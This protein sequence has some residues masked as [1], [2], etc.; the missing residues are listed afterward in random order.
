[1]PFKHKQYNSITIS[2]TYYDSDALQ[3]L[4]KEKLNNN[5]VAEWEIAFYSF[6]EEWLNESPE[7]EVKTS[8]STGIPKKIKVSKS[9]ML[10]SA[11]NTI[12]FFALKPGQKAL[13][14]L[15]CE[16][17]AGKM[18]VV[19]AFAGQLN[20]I[21]VPVSGSPLSNLNTP[22]DFAALTPLQMSN[23]LSKDQSRLNLL[24]TVILGGSPVSPD[25]KAKLQHE[26]V[27]VWET[28]GMTETLSHIA[29]RPVNGSNAEVFFTPFDGIGI[30]K[31]QRSCLVINAPFISEDPFVTNDLVEIN[32]KG[33]FRIKGRYDNI[34]NTG[35]IKVSPEDVESCISHLIDQPFY[36][37][38]VPDPVLGQKLVLVMEKTP[39]DKRTFLEKI[40]S[41]LP[42]HHAPRKIVERKLH[43]TETGKIKR[44]D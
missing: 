36:I 11:L 4:C 30:T 31:D 12:G 15:P 32:D 42:P 35:G 43:L 23:E 19:R 37:S 38:S 40:K 41:V 28:Y 7:V 44:V 18:M 33:K 2:G 6:I 14:C 24:R 22:V 10:Q 26:P 25:L 27:N 8:G 9:A 5:S 1:M 16:Y 34:I 39:D 20:L 21:P 29:L 3:K 13:L 17:I